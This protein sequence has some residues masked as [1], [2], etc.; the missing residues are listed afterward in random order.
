MINKS[1]KYFF[2]VCLDKSEG[3]DEVKFKENVNAKCIFTKLIGLNEEKEKLIKIFKYTGEIKEEVNFYF[4]YDN[5]NYQLT[6]NNP[7]GHIFIFD[8]VLKK[9]SIFFRI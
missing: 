2:L 6:I 9:L 4:Y 5:N 8:I 1:N 3:N 7:K